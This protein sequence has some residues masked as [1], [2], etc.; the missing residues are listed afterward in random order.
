MG[1][2][3]RGSR[4]SLM[5]KVALSR[6]ASL[7]LSANR[8][9]SRQQSEGLGVALRTTPSSSNH[10]RR[11]RSRLG[12]DTHGAQ[13]CGATPAPACLLNRYE[14]QLGVGTTQRRVPVPEVV[15]VSVL[16]EPALT[17]S[18]EQGI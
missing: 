12:G 2:G 3:A 7:A 9:G 10:D 11:D 6:R 4:R 8:A 15:Q 5:S 13:R 17:A 1:L 18:T 14:P 16:E